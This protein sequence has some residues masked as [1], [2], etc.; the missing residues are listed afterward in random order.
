MG[1]DGQVKLW[2]HINDKE[3]YS[4]R[5]VGKGTCCDLLGYSDANQGRVVVVGFDNGIVRVLLMSPQDFTVLKAFKAHDDP[6]VKVKFS[7]D[8]GMLATCS[9]TG[10]I[11]F[12]VISGMDNV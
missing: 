12:F 3:Y 1:E 4:R 10:E 7:P 6:I 5:F 2:D 8:Q 11:F 9:S